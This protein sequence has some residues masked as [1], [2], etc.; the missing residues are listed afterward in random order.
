MLDERNW[1]ADD[2]AMKGMEMHM[3]KEAKEQVGV[4]IANLA[5]AT[6]W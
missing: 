1:R 5:I 2:G 3:N 4:L 6:G